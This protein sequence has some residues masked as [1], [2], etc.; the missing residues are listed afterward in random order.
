[1]AAPVVIYIKRWHRR[2]QILIQTRENN[3]IHCNTNSAIIR[4]LVTLKTRFI[5]NLEDR[6]LDFIF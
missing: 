5:P 4:F 1:M 2:V 6:I 3:F